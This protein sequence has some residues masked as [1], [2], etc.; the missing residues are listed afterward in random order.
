VPSGVIV[1]DV[2]GLCVVVP[3]FTAAASTVLG[4]VLRVWDT[5]C[6]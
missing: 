2:S 3:S 6:G 5:G 1:G 4:A